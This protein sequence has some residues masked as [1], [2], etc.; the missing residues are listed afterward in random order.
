MLELIEGDDMHVTFL[1]WHLIHGPHREQL[2]N[3][4]MEVFLSILDS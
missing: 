1:K 3:L 2:R 4:L